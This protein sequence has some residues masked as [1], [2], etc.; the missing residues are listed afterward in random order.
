MK[1]LVLHG[2]GDLRYEELEDPKI[3]KDEVLL[4][5]MACGICGSDIPRVFSKGTYHFPTIPGHEFSGQV[6]QVGEQ[7][8]REWIGKRAAVFPML[9]CMKCE[10]CQVGQYA[11]CKDYNYYGSR[12]DGGFAEYLAV[13]PWNLV[14]IPNSLSYEEAAMTEPAAVAV[15]ALSQVG[16]EMGDNVVIFG[17]GPI[18]LMLGQWAKAWGADKVMLVDIDE[19]KV[20][21]AKMQGFKYVW[22]SSKGDAAAWVKEVTKGRGADV[23][24]EGAGVSVTFEQ[25]LIS[26]RTFGRVVLMGNPAGD[27]RLSQKAYWEILRKQLIIR[28][29]WNSGYAELAKNDWKLSIRAME[30]RKLNVKPFITHRVGLEKG[31]EAFEMIRDK[32]EFTNKVMVVMDK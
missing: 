14:E 7:V 22:N 29:T 1:A 12:C 15:H 17:A 32:K 2:I 23:A 8:S 30:T 21:F 27:M 16:I 6:L 4:K 24:V 28:G 3:N 18:G 13:R 20:E 25:A 31:V 19:A 5:V 9:P 11:Q 26:V 10:A